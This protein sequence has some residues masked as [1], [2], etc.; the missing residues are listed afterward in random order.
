[1]MILGGDA[2]TVL[3]VALIGFLIVA[4]IAIR[5]FTRVLNQWD[6]IRD[7]LLRFAKLTTALAFAAGRLAPG[8]STSAPDI[9]R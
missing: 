6:S 1:M 4:G 2:Q 8:E 9:T 3:H 5:D 7:S